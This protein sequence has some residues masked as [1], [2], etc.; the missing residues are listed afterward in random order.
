MPETKIGLGQAEKPPPLWYRRMS[1]A[2]IIF[3]IP[4]LSGLI[5]SLGLT[6]IV[7]NR[8]LSILTFTPALIK[9]IGIMLGNGQVYSP[10]NET[11]DRINNKPLI[12]LVIGLL[13][14]SC[15]A[16][17]KAHQYVASHPEE[18]AKECADAY[19]VKEVL[20][21]GD[22]VTIR[23][24]VTGEGT[25]ITEYIKGDVDTVVIT[26][27]LPAKTIYTTKTIHDTLVKENTAR[28]SAIAK[29]FNDA[30]NRE[31]ILQE[32][33]Q[34]LKAR[35]KNKALIPWWIIILL[36]VVAG[37]WAAWRIRAGALNSLLKK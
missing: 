7:T 28:V 31:K 29:D 18:F 26:K 11:I 1:N 22:T 3:V 8:W 5:Q 36:I 4:S 10:S 34:E 19:P 33:Y 21:P 30:L 13:L 27:T 16:S 15:N 20:L 6:D 14:M 17:K 32:K 9:G 37:S 12:I 24:T 35:V 2:L 23:D 25:T